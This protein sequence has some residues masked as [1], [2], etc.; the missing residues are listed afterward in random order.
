M[1]LFNGG[2]HM[3]E[4]N[5]IKF[6][7]KVFRAIEQIIKQDFPDL[8]YN[9]KFRFWIDEVF[10]DYFGNFDPCLDNLSDGPNGYKE[11]LDYFWYSNDLG[12]FKCRF[13]SEIEMRKRK[14]WFRQSRMT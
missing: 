1:Y 8:E 6:E 9:E 5:L 7:T 3:K 14:G 12:L 2:I 11:V 4:K 13:S 10:S